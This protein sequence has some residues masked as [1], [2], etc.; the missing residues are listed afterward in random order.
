MLEGSEGDQA[1]SRHEVLHHL[2]LSSDS[3]ATPPHPCSK[4]TLGRHL[5][6]HLPHKAISL[7]NT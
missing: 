5:D 6:I 2:T 1:K 3:S 4:V 7:S